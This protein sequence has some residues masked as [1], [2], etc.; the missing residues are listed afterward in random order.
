MSD[1]T[2]VA[3]RQFGKEC[4]APKDFP[5]HEDL[6]KKVQENHANTMRYVRSAYTGQKI[7][8]KDHGD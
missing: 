1:K 5:K 3:R 6:I 2:P 7:L 4:K 8:L